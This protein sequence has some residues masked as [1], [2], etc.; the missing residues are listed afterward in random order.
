M[1]IKD[2]MI[3]LTG[4]LKPDHTLKKAAAML[5]SAKR[6]EDKVGVK[7]LPVVDER[8][9]LV[10][11]LSMRDIL[12]ATFP[13]YMSKLHLGEFTWD[14]MLEEHAKKVADHRVEQYMSRNVLTVTE[15]DSLMECVEIMLKNNV[16]R[17]PVIDKEA[18]VIG[19][20]YEREIFEA[21]AK[22]MF[23]I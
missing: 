5:I 7:G 11:M 21:I 17:L 14:G 12:K 10:G 19:V 15:D 23:G 1:T 13:S 9:R 16:K 3:P 2:L 6:R 18:N 4:F 20:V 8:G 22:A